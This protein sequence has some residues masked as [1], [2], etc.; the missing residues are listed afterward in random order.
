MP[1]HAYIA[2]GSNLGNRQANIGGA[3]H[4][5]RLFPQTLVTRQSSVRE[6][7]PVGGPAGQGDYLNSVV[8]MSTGLEAAELLQG[9][10]A[11]EH[12]MGRARGCEVR[13]GPRVIDLD[14]LLFDQVVCDGPALTIPHPRLAERLFVLVPLAE[15]AP[16]LLHPVLQLPIRQLLAQAAA[17]SSS[18]GTNQC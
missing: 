13:H 11:I 12:S 8:E 14:L 16:N 18:L 3:I 6:T 2:L 15:L 4:R 17:G 7:K 10:L 1:H 9:L 5:M